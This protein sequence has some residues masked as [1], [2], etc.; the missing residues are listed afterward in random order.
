MKKLMMFS[1]KECEKEEGGGSDSKHLCDNT[2]LGLPN[3]IK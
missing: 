3:L 1:W 2:S